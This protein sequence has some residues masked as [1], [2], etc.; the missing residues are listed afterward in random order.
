MPYAMLVVVRVSMGAL[1]D[2][3]LRALLREFAFRFLC[4]MGRAGTGTREAEAIGQISPA[5]RTQRRFR[6]GALIGDFGTGFPKADT[7]R[8]HGAAR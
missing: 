7:E 5:G 1:F 8:C 4:V 3:G 6:L 2:G